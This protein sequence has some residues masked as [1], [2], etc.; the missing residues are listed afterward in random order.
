MTALLAGRFI[1]QTFLAPKAG[2]GLQPADDQSNPTLPR[3]ADSDG[4]APAYAPDNRNAAPPLAND[5]G[6]EAGYV[7]ADK[8]T[9]QAV[10]GSIEQLQPGPA[11]PREDWKPPRR[12]RLTSRRQHAERASRPAG[13]GDPLYGAAGARVDRARDR[14]LQ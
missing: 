10:V 5:P 1:H 14:D 3:K 4:R 13:C 11:P 2:S 12:L 8:R 6:I 9:R 7:L